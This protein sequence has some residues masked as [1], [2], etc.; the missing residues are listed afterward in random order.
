MGNSLEVQWLGLCTF[1]AADVGSVPGQGT[2]ILQG[3]WCSQKKVKLKASAYPFINVV[4]YLDFLRYQTSMRTPTILSPSPP[5]FQL[6]TSVHF[7]CMLLKLTAFPFNQQ[8]LQY[9]DYVNSVH[10]NGPQLL[11]LQIQYFCHL[12]RMWQMEYFF[13]HAYISQN[14]ATIC[15]IFFMLH[16]SLLHIWAMTLL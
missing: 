11:P 10:C 6:S 1:T 4:Q 2:K 16:F 15:F 12:R 14:Q 8:H 5:H 3:A 7:A 9:G 13:L